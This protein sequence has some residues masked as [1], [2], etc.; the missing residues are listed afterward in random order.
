[1]TLTAKFRR[2][3]ESSWKGPLGGHLF[4]SQLNPEP[5]LSNPPRHDF[6]HPQSQVFS[7]RAGAVGTVLY[8]KRGSI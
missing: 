8:T 6:E 5:Y 7:S 4:Y 2:I 1:M 3:K